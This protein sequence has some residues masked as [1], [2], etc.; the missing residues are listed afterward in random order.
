MRL[1]GLGWNLAWALSNFSMSF[2]KFVGA[3]MFKVWN[4]VSLQD[5]S[6]ESWYLQFVLLPCAFISERTKNHSRVP[7]N[8][9]ERE[10]SKSKEI[11]QRRPENEQHN[12]GRAYSETVTWALA[13]QN[14]S[15]TRT[16][17]YHRGKPDPKQGSTQR[18][19]RRDKTA[20]RT[21]ILSYL[22]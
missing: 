10:E 19:S 15:V 11:I 17:R 9:G 12:Q 16:K 3:T 21:L 13:N 7:T 4:T 2:Q 14:K 6:R 5:D 1:E 8:T 22:C 18:H 20:N